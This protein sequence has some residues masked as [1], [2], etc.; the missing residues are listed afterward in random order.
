M[1]DLSL[2]Q[3]SS[4][5]YEFSPIPRLATNMSY[6]TTLL[7][8]SGF[9]FVCHVWCHLKSCPLH[10][11]IKTN[12]VD[13]KC[14]FNKKSLKVIKVKPSRNWAKLWLDVLIVYLWFLKLL[15]AISH[16]AW[17]WVWCTTR[18]GILWSWQQLRLGSLELLTVCVLQP[19]I[20]CWARSTRHNMGIGVL[21][22]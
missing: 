4:S 21:L 13:G 22:R 20:A 11:L 5:M 17:V 9:L 6:Q 12:N 10:T 15:S 7:A 16:W 18:N 8:P 19:L 2:W 3:V 14:N 1:V